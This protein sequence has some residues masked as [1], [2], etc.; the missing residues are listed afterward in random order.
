MFRITRR[1]LT[2]PLHRAVLEKAKEAA[3][4]SGVCRDDSECTEDS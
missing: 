3:T 4:S 2:H 1:R